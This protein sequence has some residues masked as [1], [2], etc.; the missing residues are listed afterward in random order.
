MS[1]N[2]VIG[3]THHT[4]NGWWGCFKVS[5]GCQNCY[6]EAFSKRTGHDIWGPPKTTS[7]RLFGD[8]HWSEPLKWNADAEK[9]GERRRVFGF[10]MA[11]VFEDHPDVWD[12]RQ[13]LW[14]LI[15]ETPALDWLLLTKRPENVM[16]MVPMDWTEHGFPLNVWLGTS[17]ENQDA[18]DERIPH[19][20]ATPAAVRFLSCEPL[21]GPVNLSKVCMG[22]RPG[23]LGEF[24]QYIDA[25]DGWHIDGMGFGRRLQRGLDWVIVGGE[26]GP[27]H[28]EM[29]MP[30]LVNLTHQCRDADVPVYVKQDSGAY[31]G[32]QGHIHDNFWLH[33]F[34]PAPA[35]RASE[36]T[37]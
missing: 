17:V 28:R 31:P 34:P 23:Q 13:R 7:R 4:F 18:A 37:P 32:R 24:D 22:K 1:E 25:V 11:D 12:A 5:P 20:L 19:L 29:Q 9:A 14:D 8:K 30:W 16:G 33:E 15:E 35:A 21:L 2:S 3:W 36:A 27:G 26:S 6:A 10:S